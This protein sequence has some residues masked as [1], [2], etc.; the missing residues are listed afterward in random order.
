MSQP[1]RP[2]PDRAA[3]DRPGDDAPAASPDTPLPDASR[4]DTPRPDA[5][6]P[7]PRRAEDAGQAA[8]DA[9]RRARREAAK[10]RFGGDL[11]GPGDRAAAWINSI[12]S[13]HAFIRALHLNLHRVGE[14]GFR[15]GQ[16]L[17]GQIR[18]L[19]RKHGLRTV[20]SLRGGVL[21]G[22][23]PLE[24]EACAAEGIAFES[25]VL[26]SRALPSREEIAALDALI[27]RIARPALFH[28]KAGADRA[29]LMSALWLILAEG[30]SVAEARGQLSW[31]YGHLRSG[32]TGILDLFMDHAE[33]AEARGLPFR[34]W[35][36]TEYDREA[37][38]AEFKAAAPGGFGTWLVDKALKRE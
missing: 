23:A 31:R 37:L 2:Q 11:S 32:P 6:Q 20:I 14:S 3:T 36:A 19:A 15:S 5:P 26:R 27:A 16:P 28:C 35:I 24:R 30:R 1:P 21:F 13:D 34:A 29:G 17:P 4:P 22:S 9:R 18:R 8:R 10:R 7:A 33:A 12:F 25:F 38:T